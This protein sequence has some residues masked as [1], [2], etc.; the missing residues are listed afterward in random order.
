M[1]KK[2]KILIGIGISVLIA[3]II[4]ALLLWNGFSA[5]PQEG[6]KEIVFE[7]VAKDGASQE[8]EIATD[9][10]Y[11]AEALVEKGLIEYAADG[12]YTTINGITA[13]WNTDQ[14]W[15][16]ITKDGEQTAVGMNQQPIADGEHYEATY[17]MGY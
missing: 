12:F 11:L 8:F 5:K 14:G 4:G 6:S 1:Q 15:W 7:V 17:T 9:A 10:D 3:A 2:Q 13:D 16:A